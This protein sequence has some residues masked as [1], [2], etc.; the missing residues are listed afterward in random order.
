MSIGNTVF[1]K[2]GGIS[3]ALAIALGA[4]GAHNK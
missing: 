3:G 2:I 1:T 4:Y